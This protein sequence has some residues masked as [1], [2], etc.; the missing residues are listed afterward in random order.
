MTLSLIPT[1]PLPLALGPRMRRKHNVTRQPQHGA[2]QRPEPQRLV[3]EQRVPDARGP[4]LGRARALGVEGELLR[5]GV[6]AEEGDERVRR[7]CFGF[8]QGD[9]RGG[10]GGRRREQVVRGCAGAVFAADEG[11]DARAEGAGCTEGC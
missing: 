6:C 7:D 5:C 8:E 1:K 11:A 2:R 10:G 4:V 9:E 3:V